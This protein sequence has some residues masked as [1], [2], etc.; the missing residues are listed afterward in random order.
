MYPDRFSPRSQLV[1]I[2][3]ICEGGALER[4][5]TYSNA[6]CDVE[7]DVEIGGP[8]FRTSQM[9]YIY[10]LLIFLKTSQ[11]HAVGQKIKVGRDL[12]D[13]KTIKLNLGNVKKDNLHSRT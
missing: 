5:C 8:H 7:R 13:H 1:Y 9:V 10:I 11:N 6:N 3:T 12:G 4:L 2:Y